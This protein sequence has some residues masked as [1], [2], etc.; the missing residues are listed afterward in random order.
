MLFQALLVKLT[1]CVGLTVLSLLLVQTMKEAEARRQ[2][3][4][5]KSASPSPWVA[6]PANPNSKDEAT[7]LMSGSATTTNNASNGRERKTNRT[8]RMLLVVVVLFLVT[9]FPQGVINLLSGVLDNF[10][11]QVYMA[12]GDLLD[13]L[14]LI[15]NGINFILYCTMSKQFRD[16]FVH[17]FHLQPAATAIHRFF[18][19]GRG[20]GSG[21]EVDGGATNGGRQLPPAAARGERRNSQ[22]SGE[23]GEASNLRVPATTTTTMTEVEDR[24]LTVL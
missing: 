9:E 16:T 13:I 10:V 17:C 18:S 22:T 4:R 19:K 20:G 21:G 6:T 8:T 5:A 2:N 23:V 24:K 11:E 12:L 3:L 7:G 1:P 15:N 14:A